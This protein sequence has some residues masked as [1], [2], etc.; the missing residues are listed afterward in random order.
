[1]LGNRGP[2]ACRKRK[3]GPSSIRLETPKDTSGNRRRS[4]LSNAIVSVRRLDRM[5]GVK[6]VLDEVGQQ[7]GLQDS[8]ERLVL[9]G[10]G[11]F[12]AKAAPNSNAI[13]RD[14]TSGIRVDVNPTNG[15][16]VLGFDL[17][18]QNPEPTTV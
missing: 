3:Y 6:V 17:K 18:T 10:H 4:R 13:G 14:V 11:L 1:M 15:F 12:Q 7:A 16:W 2:R 9:A 5:F 8:S